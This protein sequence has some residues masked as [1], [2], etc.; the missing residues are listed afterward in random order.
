MVAL[1]GKISGRH[2]SKSKLRAQNLFRCSIAIAPA[3]STMM[4]PVQ[5]PTSADKAYP[6]LIPTYM[7]KVRNTF[8]E[9]DEPEEDTVPRRRCQS[10]PPRHAAPVE[11]ATSDVSMDEVASESGVVC[12]QVLLISPKEILGHDAQAEALTEKVKPALL[13]Q[14]GS[15][16]HPDIC[17]RPCLFFMAG[18]CTNG[19]SCDYCHMPH[20]ARAPHLD[21]RQRLLVGNLTEPEL[22]NLLLVYLKERAEISGF[23]KEATEVLEILRRRANIV[24]GAEPELPRLPRQCQPKLHYMMQKM[25][26]QALIGLALKSKYANEAFAEEVSAALTRMRSSMLVAAAVEAA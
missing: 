19:E 17:R 11:C 10:A 5:L 21:K 20:E 18:N 4:C 8:L 2:T 12:Q 7:T 15:M 6:M 14:P 23:A 3:T 26:F 25:T 9:F 22:L 16:G 24:P 1:L 13:R